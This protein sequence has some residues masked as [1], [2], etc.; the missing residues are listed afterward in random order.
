M[1]LTYQWLG[2]GFI[3]LFGMAIETICWWLFTSDEAM[4]KMVADHRN[5][6]ETITEEY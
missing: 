4:N 6:S 3:A 1:V 5:S 2:S